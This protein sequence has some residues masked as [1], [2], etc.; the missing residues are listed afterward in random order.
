MHDSYLC[1]RGLIER[2]KIQEEVL[3]VKIGWQRKHKK[4][5]TRNFLQETEICCV[6]NVIKEILDYL[7]KYILKGER[8]VDQSFSSVSFDGCDSALTG[9]SFRKSAFSD[10]SFDHAKLT[11]TDFTEGLFHKVSMKHVQSKDVVYAGAKFYDFIISGDSVFNG[12]VFADV[13]F[14]ANVIGGET[15]GETYFQFR[16]VSCSKANFVNCKIQN[17]DFK[18]SVFSQS[19]L[20]YA[21]ILKCIFSYADFGKAVLANAILS[22]CTFNSASLED[23][24][25]VYT[26][27]KDCEADKAR[28]AGAN[29]TESELP[30]CFFRDV[31]ADNSCFSG[32]VLKRCHFDNAIM[33]HTDFSRADIQDCTFKETNLMDSLLIGEHKEGSGEEKS[34]IVRTDYTGANMTGSQ[35]RGISYV[36]CVFDEAILNDVML[37]NVV[38]ENCSFRNTQLKEVYIRNVKWINCRACDH[39]GVFLDKMEF[40][41]EEDRLHFADICKQAEQGRLQAEQIIYERKSTRAFMPGYRV[42]RDKQRKILQAGLQAPSPKNRQP[43]YFTVVDG[44]EKLNDIANLMEKEIENLKAERAGSGRESTDLEMAVQTAKLVQILPL[45][46]SGLDKKYSI[47]SEE[48]AILSSSHLAQE[49]HIRVLKRILEKTGIREEEIELEPSASTGRISFDIWKSKEHARKR[50]LYHPCA[51]NHI[52]FMLVQRELTGKKDYYRDWN[53]PI[54]QWVLE[55]ISEFSE[56]QKDRIKL[57]LD[58][59]M[60]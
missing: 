53:S 28:M 44:L 33:N 9:V 37:I 34:K 22:Q 52:G 1:A 21:Q 18:N 5:Q 11:G 49:Q 42:D 29:L 15:E 7:K 12:S 59:L 17:V 36:A 2:K 14:N 55:L 48:L 4:V 20:S 35:I 26:C 16:Q 6:R 32:A 23:V 51:G 41:A 31:Y 60:E 47:N 13:N 43:W 57:V 46:L 45:Y 19:L 58:K 40:A 8:L 30:D 54:Q 10:C 25:G 56:Y 50:K 38:F 24:T 39:F 27:W 3:P